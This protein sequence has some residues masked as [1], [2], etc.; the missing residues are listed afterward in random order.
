MLNICFQ[1]KVR[2]ERAFLFLCAPIIA[3]LLMWPQVSASNQVLIAKSKIERARE[4]VS[5]GERVAA[6]KALKELSHDSPIVA[7]KPR[8]KTN[9]VSRELT[10]AWL[11]I[12]EV[13][14]T[15]KGQSQFSMAESIWLAK[16][17]DALDVLTPLMKTEDANLQV[18]RLGARSALRVSDCVR[19][20]AFIQQAELVFPIGSDVKLLR[21]QAQDCLNGLNPSAPALKLSPDAEVGEIDGALRLLSVKDAVRRK[22][23]KSA[24]AFLNSWETSKS[25][26]AT[27]NP[28]FWYWKWRVSV[29][30][31]AV[32]SA[33][34]SNYEGS[35]DRTAAR[36]YL[37]LCSEMTPRRRKNFAVYPELCLATESVESD[38]KSS[39]KAG[40]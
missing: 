36:K 34:N 5:K 2:I 10:Q 17:K 15:D 23:V 12:A 18:S 7:A 40:T 28:E 22:D 6:A 8:S 32:E 4:L 31:A 16:P 21:Q 19:A 9:E 39:D 30:A 20:D 38:L 11:E 25:A 3:S 26:N 27:D 37:R 29:A 14:L 1:R 24:R 33:S 35:R 13:F